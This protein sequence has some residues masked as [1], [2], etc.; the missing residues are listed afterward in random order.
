MI[1]EMCTWRVEMIESEAEKERERG[2]CAR[3]K[4]DL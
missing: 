3:N 2:M 4:S 1:E